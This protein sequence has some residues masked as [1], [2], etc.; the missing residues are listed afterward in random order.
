M[1]DFR[2]DL[3]R[4][5]VP[6]LI[7]HGTTDRILP[8]EATGDRLHQALPGSDY[9]VIEGG[10]HGLLWTHATEVNAALLAFLAT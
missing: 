8:I 4:L 5:D 6:T 1:T 7:V 2:G 3:G 10:P 9:A